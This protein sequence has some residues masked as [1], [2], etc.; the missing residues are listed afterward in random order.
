MTAH[1]STEK[2]KE[3]ICDREEFVDYLSLILQNQKNSLMPDGH[4]S[5]PF[6]G[7][8]LYALFKLVY[9]DNDGYE[10]VKNDAFVLFLKFFFILF[11][12]FCFNLLNF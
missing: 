1:L 11:A 8:D 7:I 12:L 9:I 4:L 6:G 3:M 10:K 5:F 2:G